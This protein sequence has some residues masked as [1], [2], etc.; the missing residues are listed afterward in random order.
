[1]EGSLTVLLGKIWY[2]P[3]ATGGARL[4]IGYLDICQQKKVIS[5]FPSLSL[6]RQQSPF[7]G[8]LE[9]TR[10]YVHAPLEKHFGREKLWNAHPFSAVSCSHWLNVRPT[11]WKCR[12]KIWSIHWPLCYLRYEHFS[13]GWSQHLPTIAIMQNGFGLRAILYYVCPC[14]SMGW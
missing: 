9:E 4:V 2:W 12:E 8:R 10:N 5:H 13:T 11:P 6:F 1:M 7:L 14:C 3:E